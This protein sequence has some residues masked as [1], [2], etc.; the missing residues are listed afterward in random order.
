[1]LILCNR[2]TKPGAR[3]AQKKVKHRA[4]FLSAVIAVAAV[5]A[6]VFAGAPAARAASGKT[7]AGLA[8]HV[9][10]AYAQHWQY[11][12]GGY[13][14]R[15]S[16]VRG[17]D[18]SGL[19]K[20]YLWWTGENSDPRP[21]IS[22]AGSSGSMLNS[23]SEK[24]TINYFNSAS[25]PRVHGLILYQPGHVGV[26]V[27]NNRAVD[28][29]GTGY[30]MKYEP[31]F[32]RAKPKWTMWFKLPQISYPT[33]GF[34]TFEGKK[35]Y[36]ENGQYVVSTSRTIGGVTYSFGASGA[37]TSSSGRSAPA[38]AKPAAKSSAAKRATASASSPAQSADSAAAR[39]YAVLKAG[40]KSASVKQ[41]QQRL[42]DLG[43]YY[44]M[45]NTYYD[46]FVTD[47]VSAYQKTAGL[48]ATGVADDATQKSL[49][50]ASA[51]QNPNPGSI[52]PGM[53]SSLVTRMRTRLIALGYMRGKPGIFYDEATERAVLAYQKASGMPQ[54]GTMD[55]DALKQLYSDSAVKAVSAPSSASAS[56]AAASSAAESSGAFQAPFYGNALPTANAAAF[57]QERG[58]PTSQGGLAL[59][60]VFLSGILTAAI[61]LAKKRK[62][63]SRISAA[64]VPVLKAILARWKKN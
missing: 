12:A 40:S 44:E 35:Y 56:K 24:G 48:K 21:G 11:R 15:V 38:A 2:W 18:C 5:S 64:D 30:N 45:V 16:G 3:E 59:T 37:V 14:Q 41:L 49:Y 27:G 62:T 31:V 42:T 26:Y 39:T 29:R 19:I 53:H 9:L 57:Q 25:L 34:V 20:S 52:T 28:N 10:K 46:A 54:T 13:G 7:G 55:A 50:S 43:Y 23:A 1:M 33:R 47:A 36:Y 32:G 4:F 51:P 22:V 63:G 17:T 58:T 61:M 8:E 6:A 60:F